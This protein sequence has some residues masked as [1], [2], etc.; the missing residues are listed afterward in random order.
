MGAGL[1]QSRGPG[2]EGRCRNWGNGTADLGQRKRGQTPPRCSGPLTICEWGRFERG[3]RE[4]GNGCFG[5]SSC[6]SR[7]L[8]TDLSVFQAAPEREWTRPA[9]LSQGGPLIALSCLRS[10]EF[11][12]GG[13]MWKSGVRVSPQGGIVFWKARRGDC[14]SASFVYCVFLLFIPERKQEETCRK[15]FSWFFY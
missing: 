14:A 1:P 7:T 11:C 4:G 10:L 6:K 5:T 9:A 12:R 2:G 13:E 15:V 3:C 8:F